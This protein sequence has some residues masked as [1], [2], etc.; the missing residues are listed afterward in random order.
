MKL[1]T[2]SIKWAID[3]LEKE[4]DTDIFPKPIEISII[5]EC[6]DDVIRVLSNIDIGNYKWRP[7]RR[8]LIPKDELSYRV[9]TQLDPLDS[10]FLSAIIKSFGQKIEDNRIPINKRVVFGNRFNPAKNG[11]L[12][13]SDGQ[14]GKFWKAAKSRAKKNKYMLRFDI[15]DFYNQIYH[16][17]IENQL[18]ECGLPN[19]VKN[20]I[21]DLFNV[22]TLKV[23]RGIPVGPHSTHIIAE[24]AL[25][26][27]DNSLT[28][29]GI[30]YCRFMD[31]FFAF[32]KTEV[33]CKIILNKAA[34]ILD[35][36]QRLILQRFK[37][38]IFSQEDF[39]HE[40]DEQLTF[41]PLNDVEEKILEIVKNHSDGPYLSKIKW[42][43]LDPKD[44]E[45][46][47]RI[48]YG[49]LIDDYLKREGTPNF[50]KLRWIYRRLR[51]LGVPHAIDYT[52]D[53]LD[54]FTPIINDICEY[55]V[56]A[57][58][59]YSGNL[60]RTGKKIHKLLDNKIIK[61]SE[62]FQIALINIFSQAKELN[63]FSAFS[64][65][66]KASSENV[67][68]K[69]LLFAYSIKAT[70]WL[71]EI[72]EQYSDFNAWNKRAFLIASSCLPKD[73]RK[74]FYDSVKKSLTNED[75]LEHII[76]KWGKNK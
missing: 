33:D 9:I 22:V 13:K 8:F 32:G 15:A 17:T 37:T 11:F 54:R 49:D 59:N 2:D 4:N 58:P 66:F 41:E 65:T 56:A 73:E 29:H 71:R 3:H 6:K 10:V 21:C 25:I 38:K 35:K 39:L 50:S 5:K 19:E 40:C 34:E 20:S 60:K 16:H 67:K 27:I 47:S 23:S 30:N 24:A 64:K 31:D 48:F 53:N 42:E 72:K 57:A 36:Q 61:S 43:D 76:I 69:I 26:P 18:I 14:W 70:D 74:F 75:L 7:S 63:H 52:L 28:Y 45:F 68:R 12:Y 51:Q 62:F 46:F 55:L 44:Q 1:T